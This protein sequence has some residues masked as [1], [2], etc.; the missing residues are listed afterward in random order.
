MKMGRGHWSEGESDDAEDGC[1]SS[2]QNPPE[3]RVRVLRVQ[4]ASAVCR[5]LSPIGRI[6]R[7]VFALSHLIFA[8]IFVVK[9]QKSCKQKLHEKKGGG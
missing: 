5:H 2:Q 4:S 6:S 7:Q 1:V 3:P 8:F 9:P